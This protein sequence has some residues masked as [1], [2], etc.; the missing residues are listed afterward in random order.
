[1]KN[2]TDIAI[3]FRIH[4]SKLRG[5]MG[6]FLLTS[7]IFP[8]GMY[9]FLS[10]VAGDEHINRIQFL[11]GS[12]VFSTT[13]VSIMWVGYHLLEDRFRGRLKLF[14]TSPVKPISYILGVISFA[15]LQ[16]VIGITGLLIVAKLVGLQIHFSPLILPLLCLGL[17]S[18][19][20]IAII[21]SRF[22]N[23]M[24]QGTLITDGLGAGLVFVSPVYYSITQL[25]KSIQPA[26]Y[27]LPPTFLADGLRKVLSGNNAIAIDLIVL[28]VMATASMLISLKLTRWRED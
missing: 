18:H 16:A 27:L 13:M 10:V 21:I 9:L 3:I 4:F 23:S 19:T 26:A 11:S 6:P 17:L 24:P 1:M 8:V 28:G 14:V 15:S 12:I 20:S 5:E 7:F 2:L 25:P 22:A